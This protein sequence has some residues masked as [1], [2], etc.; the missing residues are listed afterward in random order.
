PSAPAAN[1][2]RP[3]ARLWRWWDFLGVLLLIAATVPATVM[4]PRTLHIVW[5]PGLFDDSWLLDT[6]FKA[7]RETWFGRDTAFNWGPLFQWLSSVPARCFGPSM[8]LIYDTYNT[9]P[10]WLGFLLTYAALRLLLAEEPAWKRL[11]LFLLLSVF[12]SPYDLRAP[13]ACFVFAA[14][15][16]GWYA[17]QQGRLR[18]GF[19]GGVAG[20]VCILAFLLKADCGTYAVAAL[21][22]TMG[23][24]AL[25]N[26]RAA[27]WRDYLSVLAV[28][29]VVFAA[30]VIGVNWLL[31]KPFDFRFWK[32]SI[33]FVNGFRWSAAAAMEK[34]DGV[35]LL[36]ALAAVTVIFP[37]RRA[38]R[39]GGRKAI[40][41]RSAFL[42]SAYGFCLLTLQS[43][44]VRADHNHVQFAAFPTLFLAGVALFSFPSRLAS[45][46]VAALATAISFLCSTAAIRPSMVRYRYA[47]IWNP[48]TTCPNGYGALDRACY[49]AELAKEIA[50]TAGYLDQNSRTQDRIAIFPYQYVF[51]VAAG[52]TVADGV[53]QSFLAADP[54]LR[55]FNVEGSERAAAPVGLYFPDRQLEHPTSTDLSFP[56]DGVPNFTRSPEVWL[57]LFHHYRADGEPVPG[58]V[59]LRWDPARA[60]RIV[61]TSLPLGL[62]KRTFPISNRQTTIDLGTPDWPAGGADFLRLRLKVRYGQLWKLR[63]PERYQLEITRADGSVELSSFIAEPNV[64]T[65]LWFYPWKLSEMGNYFQADESEWRQ[66]RRPSIVGLRLLLTPFDWVS[67]TPESVTLEAADAIRFSNS[68]M[69]Q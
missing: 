11:V 38:V 34:T 1:A 58:I 2:I 64:S 12:W 55:R 6:V 24:V 42:L 37:V 29:A 61:M 30:L 19:Y 68:K 31:V 57:W 60:T 21:L 22:L 17:V 7:S 26:W 27:A 16:R 59:E 49:P 3:L 36:G 65:E 52:R 39:D 54:Y 33:G 44:L 50:T 9:V 13:V 10:L 5:R 23:G 32:A 28:F 8:G 63:K 25:E 15:L 56:I 46:A 45:L 18:P 20:V 51:A 66:G 4:S 41:S 43:G 40:A 14:F 47:Q 35:Y 53:E 67:Q 69:Q 62:E 48:I